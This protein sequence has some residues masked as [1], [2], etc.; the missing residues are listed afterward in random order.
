MAEATKSRDGIVPG[1]EESDAHDNS[2]TSMRVFTKV[3]LDGGKTFR[4]WTFDDNSETGPE[5]ST[6]VPKNARF[7]N[8]DDAGTEF[9]LKDSG[10]Y[11]RQTSTLE[12][13]KFAINQFLTKAMMD[14]KKKADGEK[15]SS[16]GDSVPS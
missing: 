4:T 10:A 9:A 7:L 2:G 6:P 3:S 15:A 14:E 12:A 8:N 1:I 13:A 11:I 16:N 5:E